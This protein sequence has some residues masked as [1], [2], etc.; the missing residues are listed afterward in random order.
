MQ[1][2]ADLGVDV[3]ALGVDVAAS[4]ECPPKGYLVGVLKIT[5]DR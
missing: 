3:A 4:F 2:G 1:S 5:A